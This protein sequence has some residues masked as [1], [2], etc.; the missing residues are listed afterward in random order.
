M[1]PHSAHVSDAWSPAIFTA[2]TFGYSR[3]I[4]H[5]E[6]RGGMGPPMVDGDPMPA[7]QSLRFSAIPFRKADTTSASA[8]LPPVTFSAT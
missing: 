1:V 7:A 8:T 2:A 5:F 3:A 4:E 6:Q